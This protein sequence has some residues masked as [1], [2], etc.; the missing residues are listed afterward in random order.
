MKAVLSIEKS[1][2]ALWMRQAVFTLAEHGF[3]RVLDA[4]ITYSLLRILT[5]PE[6]GLFSVYQ[7]WVAMLFLF[8]PAIELTMFREYG[9]LKQENKLGEA[10]GAYRFFNALKL[11]FAFGFVAILAMV[12]QGV[13]SYTARGALLAIALS[14]PLS[15]AIYSY[16]REPLRFEM[17]QGI[18]AFLSLIQRVLL[19]L[20]F[21]G[22][23]YF[24]KGEPLALLVLA[25]LAFLTAGAF[26]RIFSQKFLSGVDAYSPAYWATIR[27]SFLGTVLWIHVNGV[28]T[29]MIQTFDVFALNQRGISLI[30]IGH[31]NLALKTANFFQVIPVAL[32]SSYG[33][34]LARRSHK[35]TEPGEF[36]YE[37]RVSLILSLGFLAFCLGLFFLSAK[38]GAP[39]MGFLARGKA[40]VMEIENAII[41]FRWQVAG[42]LLYCVSYPVGTYLSARGEL[43]KIVLFVNLPWMVLSVIFYS[44]AAKFGALEA[45][46][47]NV[48]V[49]GIALFLLLLRFLCA[50][51]PS[52]EV[53]GH[54]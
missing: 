7:S 44:W 28:I 1:R 45:A 52:S 6:F 54:G 17:R 26:W 25:G 5:P 42:V 35:K 40:S 18:V 16:M 11:I 30:E 24:F 41:F 22:A 31:Y 36:E 20:A 38:V 34:F 14:L 4:L 8:L 48:A 10:L 21:W 15:Q 23:A 43:K 49:Y 50:K 46:Q 32:A 33:V 9:Q 27:A 37:R 3:V 12:P 47:A 29:Q 39:L 13:L 2:L 53:M 19:I 51:P